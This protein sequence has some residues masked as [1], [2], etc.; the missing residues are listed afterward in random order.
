MSKHG[1][2]TKR[3]EALRDQAEKRHPGDEYT[4]LRAEVAKWKRYAA[5]QIK[6]ALAAEQELVLS[7]MSGIVQ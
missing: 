4:L 1:M 5:E 7:K 2:G 3:M 6:R